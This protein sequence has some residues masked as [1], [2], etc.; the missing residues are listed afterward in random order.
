MLVCCSHTSANDTLYQLSYT[1]DV[2]H[3]LSSFATAAVAESR[4][5]LHLQALMSML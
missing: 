1:P 5:L 4:V 2:L 3:D